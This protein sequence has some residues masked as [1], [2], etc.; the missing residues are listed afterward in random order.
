M[1]D[2]VRDGMSTALSF[3]KVVIHRKFPSDKFYSL[4]L[5]LARCTATLGV[6]LPMTEERA[7]LPTVRPLEITRLALTSSGLFD[8]VGEA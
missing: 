2:A 1:K 7:R 3:A 4:H 8:R 5:N 6:S